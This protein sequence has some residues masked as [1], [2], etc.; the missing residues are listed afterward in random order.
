MLYKNMELPHFLKF[1]ENEIT[2]NVNL[3]DFEK[4]VVIMSE[5]L[6]PDVK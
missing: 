4:V 6:P 3:A 5:V 2:L 1:Y